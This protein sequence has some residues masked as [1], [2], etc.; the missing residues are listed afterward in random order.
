[1]KHKV[2]IIGPIGDFGGRE[3][4]TGF[5]AKILLQDN[6]DVNVVSTT[7]CTSKSQIFEFIE[8]KQLQVLGNLV[9]KR[10]VIFRII[11]LLGYLKSKRKRPLNFYASNRFSKKIGY[12]GCALEVLKDL[13]EK[14]DLVII[15]AQISSAYVKEIVEFA[16][17]NEKQVVIRTSSRISENDVLYKDWLEKVTMFFHH[18]ESNAARLSFLDSHHYKIIDQCTF[19]EEEML[20]MECPSSFR[21]IVFIGRLSQEKGIVELVNYF[22][23][24]EKGLCLNIIGDGP[25]LNEIESLIQSSDNIKL[26]GYKSQDAI[27]DHIKNN[28]T[29]IIP[30]I[31]ESGPLVGLEAMA[32]ARLIISTRVGAMPHRLKNTLNQFW[33]DINDTKSLED[34]FLKMKRLTEDEIRTI[35][36]KN[37]EVYLLDYRK[38]TLENLYKKS[39][40]NLLKVKPTV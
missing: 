31:E 29:I 23:A 38:N 35:A 19:R 5:I 6:Y 34:V 14:T 3:L 30:S 18:S 9:I 8:P 24:Y 27:T 21:N 13:V 25:L 28:D 40:F 22:K 16:F 15:C 2:L 36:Q 4:E 17:N 33:F 12:K 20:K 11:A 7:S 39:I 26:L 10:N 37:R 1:M 32:S